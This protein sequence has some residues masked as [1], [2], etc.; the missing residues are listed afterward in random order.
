MKAHI[1]AITLAVSDLE[2][3]LR[4]Y[5]DGLGLSSPGIV[6]TEFVRD[7]RTPGG[8]VAM[9]TLDGGLILS[10]YSRTDLA[11]DAGIAPE[12][13]AGSP[14]SLGFFAES[15]EGVDHILEQAEQAGGTIVR[16]PLVRPWGIYA[17]YFSDPDGHLWEAIYFLNN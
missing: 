13:V 14:I 16:P 2:R 1:N 17:G 8:S 7:E 6:G 15:R 10:L 4:F 11:L 5:R 12:R 9:F 3:S